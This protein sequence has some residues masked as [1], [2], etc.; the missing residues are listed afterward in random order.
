LARFHLQDYVDLFRPKVALL[1][2]FTLAAGFC[3][4]GSGAPDV[5]LLLH[6]LFGTALVVAGASALNQVSERTSDSLMLRTANRPLPRGR[7][8]P[9]TVLLFGTGAALAGVAYLT[10][11]VGRS[12]PVAA[13]SFAFASYV[14]CYTPLKRATT[15]NTLL[16]AVPG[17]MPPVIGWTAASDSFDPAVVVLFSLV[18]L[19]QVPHFLAIAWIHRADYARAN[20]C[21]LPVIDPTGNQTSRHMVSYCLALILVSAIPSALG[22]TGPLYLCAATVLGAGFLASAI[23]FCCKPSDP[24]ARRVLRASLVYLPALLMVLLVEAGLKSWEGAR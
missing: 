18:F 8:R 17:A 4:A 24:Q 20:L 19:W 5:L 12:R 7:L 10:L 23:G 13:A 15:L 1:V 2:L 14:F 16:G 3:L 11:T 6:T 22:W 9:R 21:M